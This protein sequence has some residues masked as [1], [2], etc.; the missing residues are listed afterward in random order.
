M[1]FQ[2]LK[3]KNAYYSREAR[4][5]KFFYFPSKRNESKVVY[6]ARC[7]TV[8]VHDYPGSQYFE[9][10]DA[11]IE[12]YVDGDPVWAT[13]VAITNEDSYTDIAEIIFPGGRVSRPSD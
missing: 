13:T 5:L 6:T 9:A 7:Y 10:N 12:V 4:A 1:P 11:T 3:E 8:V 2:I